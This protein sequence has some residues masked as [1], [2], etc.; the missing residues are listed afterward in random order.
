MKLFDENKYKAENSPFKDLHSVVVYFT[1]YQDGLDALHELD[2]KLDNIIS[3]KGVGTYDWHEIAMDDS[4]GSIYMYGPD[5]E[6][7]FK[8][9]KPTLDKVPWMKGAIA[10]LRFGGNDADALE[11]EVEIG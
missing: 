10:V 6:Q 2:L 4:D 7:L 1:Y 3:E 5:A 8:A 11:L 9:V